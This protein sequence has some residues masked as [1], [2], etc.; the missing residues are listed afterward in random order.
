MKNLIL[1]LLAVAFSLSVGAQAKVIKLKNLPALHNPKEY[2]IANVIDDRDDKATI[3]TMKAGISGKV[4]PITLQGGPAAGLM[5]YLNDNLKQNTNTLPVE[6]HLN[7]FEVKEEKN[8]MTPQAH[9]YSE[10][11]FSARGMNVYRIT[12]H[13]YMQGG[14]D[15]SA[16]IGKLVQQAMDYHLK[17]FDDWLKDNPISAT[18]SNTEVAI[19]MMTTDSDPN[20]IPYTNGRKLQRSDFK[21]TIDDLSTAAAVTLSGVSIKYGW[22]RLGG[23]TK[24]KI[25]L[26][27]YFN[28]SLSWWRATTHTAEI[29]AHEQ[30]HFDITA[31]Y[32]C[33]LKNELE[34]AIFQ[35]EELEQQINRL[36]N[37]VE[38]QR[39]ATQQQY[40]SETQHGL[41][42]TKQAEW[43]A[44]VKTMLAE[45]TCY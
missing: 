8:G 35:P 45:Q 37:E 43:Q 10:L 15:V 29:L 9:L 25:D 36:M 13:N 14:Y 17:A 33:V 7:R 26:L 22:E 44:K 28:T 1:S 39:V 42:K 31:V 2:H 5:Q 20:L 41:N 40:D 34:Q 38:S 24:V 19:R 11:S 21:G 4:T 12:A 6:I 32:A 3:G 16:F 27:P 23:K 30:L 18:G